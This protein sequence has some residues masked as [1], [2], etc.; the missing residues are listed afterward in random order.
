MKFLLKYI[1]KYNLFLYLIVLYCIVFNTLLIL[2]GGETWMY[3]FITP[4][5]IFALYHVIYMAIS[6]KRKKRFYDVIK[7]MVQRGQKIPESW[8]DD[9]CYLII[10]K[11]V[12]KDFSSNCKVITNNKKGE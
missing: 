6:Y 2:G 12:E 10:I 8:F 4:F 11:D 3:M 9:P 5:N 7:I 1:F